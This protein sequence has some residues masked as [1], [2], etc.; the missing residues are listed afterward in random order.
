MTS[1]T[2]FFQSGTGEGAGAEAET[3][4]DAY[5]PPR[6]A[7]RSTTQ[8]AWLALN[9]AG[10]SR[11]LDRDLNHHMA[12]PVLSAAPRCHPHF[13]CVEKASSNAVMILAASASESTKDGERMIF[14]P[15]TRT[16]TPFS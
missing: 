9:S 10:A 14:G 1:N 15:E 7:Q 2:A 5:G 8:H 11:A 16:M 12:H 6:I 13:D 4:T 3:E